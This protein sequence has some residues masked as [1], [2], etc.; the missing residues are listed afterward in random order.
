MELKLIKKSQTTRVSGKT[1]L[2]IH[3]DDSQYEPRSLGD[4]VC[5]FFVKPW[6]WHLEGG[7]ECQQVMR[8]TEGDKSYWYIPFLQI[9]SDK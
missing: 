2:P 1:L 9:K 4:V 8:R 5:W 3:P 7:V 6:L